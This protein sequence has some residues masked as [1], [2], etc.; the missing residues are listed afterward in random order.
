MNW[1]SEHALEDSKLWFSWLVEHLPGFMLEGMEDESVGFLI[2][3]LRHFKSSG[4]ANLSMDG[5][6]ALIV[7]DRDEALLCHRE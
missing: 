1:D 2:D 3:A 7:A 6:M 5:E 4:G